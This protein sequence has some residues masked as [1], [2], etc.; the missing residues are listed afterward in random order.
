MD[1]LGCPFHWPSKTQ[2]APPRL[3]PRRC[4]GRSP[5][6]TLAFP[7]YLPHG[8]NPRK[9]TRGSALCRP[10]HAEMPNSGATDAPRPG[11]NEHR[12]KS[13][14]KKAF[15]RQSVRA[16]GAGRARGELALLPT[17]LHTGGGGV[18]GHVPIVPQACPCSACLDLPAP[19]LLHG[20]Q[21]A[22]LHHSPAPHCARLRLRLL[23]Q[24]PPPGGPPALHL[25]GLSA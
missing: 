25:L 6:Q 13:V 18:G 19:A 22:A 2:P 8:A 15:P 16:E 11:M 17:L 14:S 10:P 7:M 4:Q 24:P 3:P 12:S 5:T 23:A 9:G 21:R 20:S 1:I